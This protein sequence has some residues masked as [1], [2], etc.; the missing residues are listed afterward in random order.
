MAARG[1]PILYITRT[2]RVSQR[3]TVS[4]HSVLRA[5]IPV[6]KRP[7][8]TSFHV[9][10][11]VVLPR[12]LDTSA[13]HRVENKLWSSARDIPLIPASQ[14]ALS[15]NLELPC[16]GYV[17]RVGNTNLTQVNYCLQIYMSLP[18]SSTRYIYSHHASN[19]SSLQRRAVWGHCQTRLYLLDQ[20]G[21]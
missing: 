21:K 20:T 7:A 13:S 4:Q 3:Y 5:V 1:F 18:Q 17:F 8:P 15:S 9:P 19:F 2:G 16:R 6:Q 11:H 10:L 12:Y 14:T